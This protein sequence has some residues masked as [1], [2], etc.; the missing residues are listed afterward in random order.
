MND[1]TATDEHEIRI[2]CCVVLDK[3]GGHAQP[4]GNLVSFFVDKPCL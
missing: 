1:G 2:A 3:M 4:V